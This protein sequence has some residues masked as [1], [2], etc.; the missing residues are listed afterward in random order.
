MTKKINWGILSTANIGINKVIPAMQLGKYSHIVAIASR[1]LEK[2][3][4][5]AKSL[6]IEKAYGSYEALL[7]DDNI[8][9]IYNPLPNHLHF[10]TT[11]ACIKAGKHVLC[12]KPLVLEIDEL[13][14]LIKASKVHQVKVGEAFMVDTHPQWIKALEIVNSGELGDLK[15]IHGF[16]SYHNTDPKNIRNIEEFGGGGL[17]DIGCYPIHLSRFMTG[18][19]P[20]RVISTIEYDPKFKIDRLASVLMDFPT[21]QATFTCA[22]QLQHSQ[23]MAFNGTKKRMELRIPFNAPS[24]RPSKILINDGDIHEL[25]TQVIEIPVCNQYTLQG[26]E[27]SLAI[28]NNTQVPVPLENAMGNLSVIKAIFRSA[29]TNQWEK[30]VN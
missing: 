30:P 1:T 27:F 24:D 29:T 2:A 14:T 11:L 6:G 7:A 3:E 12:E 20:N 13:K 21:C 19:E 9:A 10:E 28:L 23:T 18:Q 26:D 8:D 25:Y 16:F 22:T 15:A 4:K 5:A 17:W